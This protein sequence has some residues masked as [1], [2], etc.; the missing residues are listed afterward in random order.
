LQH[1][2]PGPVLI[3]MAGIISLG[4]FYHSIEND[5]LP[6][7]R[8]EVNRLCQTR[9]RRIDRFTQLCLL[10][11]ASCMQNM[12]PQ[13]PFDLNSTGLYIGSRFAAISVTIQ[14]HQEM[15]TKGQTP[16]PAH[17]I[18]TLS[19]SAGFY[20]AKNLGL[21]GKNIFVSRADRSAEAVFDL[22]MQDLADGIVQ[23]ALIGVVDE[24]VIPTREHCKRLNLAETT[25]LG[26]ASHWFLLSTKSKH[27]LASVETVRV[28]DPAQ[29]REFLMQEMQHHPQTL[30]VY[31][32]Q[33]QRLTKDLSP[34]VAAAIH[35]YTPSVPMNVSPALTAGVLLDYVAKPW[36]GDTQQVFITAQPDEDQRIHVMKITG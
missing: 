11:S 10:G 4:S 21:S 33:L 36:S 18:N 9:F 15:M 23:H 14:V 35:E 28:F 8:T 20:V 30:H 5:E 2:S 25:P 12:R 29:W 27:P 1:H 3:D 6:D 24:G 17:F 31:A 34:S 22:A 7:I 13:E 26:E 32:P 16:K 19:N